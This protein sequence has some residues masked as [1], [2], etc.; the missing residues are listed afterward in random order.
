MRDRSQMGLNC[1]AA[2]RY[3]DQAEPRP[4][5]ILNQPPYTEARILIAGDNFGCGSSR[6]MAVWAL[7]GIGVRCI[8]APSFGDIFFN[9]CLKNGVLPVRL[10]AAE[11]GVL[12]ALVEDRSGPAFTVDLSAKSLT[13]PDGK[14]RSF[15]LVEY[16]RQA[17]LGGLDEIDA[18]LLRLGR[19]DAF[20]RDY[21]GVRPWLTY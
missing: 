1:F 18:T 13:G 14:T 5:F 7:A 6:E 19:S 15:A 20:E 11:V 17:L 8:V 16:Y 21:W 10:A 12:L 4:D 3:D 2:W 9:N